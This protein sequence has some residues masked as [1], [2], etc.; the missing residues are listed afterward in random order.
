MSVWIKIRIL[1]GFG[2]R[3]V[4]LIKITKM[5]KIGLILGVGSGAFMSVS[6]CNLF[7]VTLTFDLGMFVGF[8]GGSC[9]RDWFG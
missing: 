5:Y 8:F 3:V 1:Q 2:L 7:T 6:V 4:F 9:S